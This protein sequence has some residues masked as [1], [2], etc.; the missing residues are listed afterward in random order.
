MGIETVAEQ[1]SIDKGT[2]QRGDLAQRN[3]GT[4]RHLNIVHVLP[5]TSLRG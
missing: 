3:T 5:K 1:L 2:M 4:K